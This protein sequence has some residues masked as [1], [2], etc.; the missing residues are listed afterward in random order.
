[1]LLDGVNVDAGASVLE[2]LMVPVFMCWLRIIYNDLLTSHQLAQLFTVGCELLCGG[3]KGSLN[4]V[5]QIRKTEMQDL[6]LN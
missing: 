2:D 5:T 4:F 1:M 6:L 3:W